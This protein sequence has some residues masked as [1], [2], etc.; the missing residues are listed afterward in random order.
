MDCSEIL[1]AE[2]KKTG[3]KYKKIEELT[4]IP[5]G[6][7]TQYVN[8]RAIPKSKLICICSRLGIDSKIFGIDVRNSGHKK[9][10]NGA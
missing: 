5:E 2:I 1:K 7:L 4:G 6:T 10:A 9:A 3:F 8:G